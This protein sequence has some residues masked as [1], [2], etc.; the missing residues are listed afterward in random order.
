MSND[1]L[2]YHS[3]QSWT[4]GGKEAEIIRQVHRIMKRQ[5]VSVCS[6]EQVDTQTGQLSRRRVFRN[7]TRKMR[8]RSDREEGQHTGS[9]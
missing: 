2:G 3:V 8:P 1:T 5:N 9:C 7:G 6:S 4:S